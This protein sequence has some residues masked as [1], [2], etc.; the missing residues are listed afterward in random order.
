[1]ILEVRY[2]ISRIIYE[3][4]SGELGRT[5]RKRGGGT[6]GILGKETLKDPRCEQMYAGGSQGVIFGRTLD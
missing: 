6:E 2:Q 1:M 5:T 3:R 4:W